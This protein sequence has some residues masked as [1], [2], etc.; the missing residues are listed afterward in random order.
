MTT[1]AAPRRPRTL[2]ALA[3]LLLTAGTASACGGDDAPPAAAPTT[4]AA[5]P[6]SSAPPPGVT[7][8]GVM[9]RHFDQVTATTQQCIPSAPFLDIRSGT[10]VII[11][12]ESDAILGQS[13]LGPG[14]FDGVRTCAY[15]FSIPRVRDDA[16]KYELS[17]SG[18]HRY[19]RTQ[20]ELSAAGW[21]FEVELGKAG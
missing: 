7:V 14:K 5:A 11:R 9:R 3:A 6:S 4:P 10:A 8:T 21:K 19:P 17:I 1:F 15:E 13:K 2:A 18:S 16:E 12:D 20:A